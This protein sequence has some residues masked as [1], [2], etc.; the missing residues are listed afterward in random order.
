MNV[1]IKGMEMP[2]NCFECKIRRAC[3]DAWY[4]KTD[5]RPYSCPLE[6]QEPCEDAVS[7]EMIMRHYD[8]GEYKHVNHISRNGL[9]DYIEQLP[10]VSPKPIECDDAVSRD[11]ATYILTEL[12]ESCENGTPCYAKARVEMA[13][14]ASVTPKLPECEDVV[15]REA[16]RLV[17]MDEKEEYQTFNLDDAYE[18]GF[19]DC[20]WKVLAL[21]SVTPKQRTGKWI[22]KQSKYGIDNEFVYLCSLCGE[23][24]GFSKK[25]YCP[26]CGAKMA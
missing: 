12:I 21:P 25:N 2:E 24:V 13:A 23:N 26:N 11:E 19:N 9:L 5:Q 4:L 14:L 1:L 16:I 17:E 3:D 8:S 10:S 15:S 18:Q 6:A 20:F 7:R 22:Q